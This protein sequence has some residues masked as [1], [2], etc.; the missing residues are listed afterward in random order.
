MGHRPFH[1]GFR[2]GTISHK[3]KM[4]FHHFIHLLEGLGLA[5]VVLGMIIAWIPTVIYYRRKVR[6]IKNAA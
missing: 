6:K 3:E 5:C 1:L 4:M 2:G